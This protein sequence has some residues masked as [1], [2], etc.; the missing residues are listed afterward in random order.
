MRGIFGSLTTRGRSFVAAGCFFG[1]ELLVCVC[2]C[3]LANSF[4]FVAIES[5]GFSSALS[6]V[7]ASIVW[8]GV[9]DRPDAAHTIAPTASTPAATVAMMA[10]LF[11]WGAFFFFFL[12]SRWVE[13]RVVDRGPGIAWRGTARPPCGGAAVR[14]G[15][16]R[17]G[18]VVLRAQRSDP[19][20]QHGSARVPARHVRAQSSRVLSGR[21]RCRR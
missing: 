7:F 2:V 14:A 1:V 11:T 17:S 8:A 5:T 13:L 4:A 6:G 19:R 16:P 3:G 20:A 10:A 15:R 21:L 9:F 12:G 18:A